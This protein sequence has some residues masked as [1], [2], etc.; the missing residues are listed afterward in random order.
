MAEGC[1]TRFALLQCYYE[2]PCFVQDYKCKIPA[3][4]KN[5]N[6]M[7]KCI[8]YYRL[9]FVLIALR[10]IGCRVVPVYH[11]AYQRLNLIAAPGDIKICFSEEV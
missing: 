9:V 6:Q 10:D 4:E 3:L 1:L 2:N 8:F 5:I 7:V 11:T